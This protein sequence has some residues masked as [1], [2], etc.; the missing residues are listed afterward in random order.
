MSPE[1]LGD[2]QYSTK[3]DVW[4]FGI[5]V[6]EVLEQQ[7]PHLNEDPITIGRRIRDEG[8]IPQLS[9]SSSQ[10]SESIVSVMK[11]CCQVSPSARPTIE[12]V[13]EKLEQI[14]V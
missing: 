9:S 14:T 7:E 4:S 3:S 12:Q 2:K 5:L 8:V 6:F 13:L 10:I 11:Q 1:S